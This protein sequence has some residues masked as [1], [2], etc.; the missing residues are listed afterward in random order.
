MIGGMPARTALR[1]THGSTLLLATALVA[2]SG[3]DGMTGE[4]AGSTGETSNATATTSGSTSAGS[5]SESES[6]STSAGSNSDSNSGM[7]DPSAGPTTTASSDT[8]DP[9]TTTADPTDTDATT[10]DT[11]DTTD[12]TDA[13]TAVDPTEGMTTDMTTGTTGPICEPQNVCGDDCCVEGEICKAGVCKIDCKPGD[14]MGG[15]MVDKSFIWVPDTAAGTVAKINTQTMTEL[16]RYR[17]GPSGGTESPSRTAVSADGRIV[18]V[19]NRGTGRAT[20]VAANL[21]DCIDKNSNGV[22]ETSQNPGDIKAWLGDE[23]VLWSVVLGE[24]SQQYTHGPR[25]ITWTLGTWNED[26]CKYENPKVWL[27]YTSKVTTTA[28]IV[29]LDGAS[30]TLEETV[31][32][33]NWVGQG[34]AP[35]GG[36][37]DPQQRPWF[38]GLRG[39]LVRIN[40][41]QNPITASRWTQ[42]GNVQSYGMT[43]DSGGNPWMA[44][45][46]G[47]VS[48]YDIVAN[49]WVN[50]ANTSACHRG[51]AIDNNGHAWV[52]SNS[53]CQVVQIDAKTRTLIA[54]H[55]PVLNGQAKCSTA[56]GV[57][58]DVEGY[59]WVV[60]QAGWGWKIDP[61][62]PQPQFWQYMP[63][64]GNHYVYSDMTGGQLQSVIPQ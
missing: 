8:T 29:R 28:H 59:V 21:D 5:A 58:V 37:L 36:A 15:G 25:G 30:G 48:T 52:A 11:T 57:S 62:A 41:D 33:P 45:C 51:M 6:G 49:Q 3:D 13:T 9:S 2:C 12:T 47:P 7:T 60:D 38:T 10:S 20:A 54:K 56:I 22:I 53:P 42:P 50:V 23:C 17:T 39:E 16:A 64:P 31:P 61:D 34:Y 24:W 19:N 46:S 4:T 32:L 55:N 40:T 35:Y 27:G 1:L 18:V 44:G 26:T 43:V 63:I 14:G